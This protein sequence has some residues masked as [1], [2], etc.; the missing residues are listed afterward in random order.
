MKNIII[1]C[2]SVLGVVHGVDTE[3]KKTLLVGVRPREFATRDYY[4]TL[5]PNTG[6]WALTDPYDSSNGAT[7]EKKV[8]FLLGFMNFYQKKVGFNGVRGHDLAYDFGDIY[9]ARPNKAFIQKL[10][11]DFLKN[12]DITDKEKQDLSYVVTKN[13]VLDDEGV[14]SLLDKSFPSTITDP[15]IMYGMPFVDKGDLTEEGQKHKD[16]FDTVIVDHNVMKF[17]VDDIKQE[18]VDRAI[19]ALN[20]LLKVGGDLIV[21]NP[22]NEMLGCRDYIGKEAYDLFI[23][24]GYS[25]EIACEVGKSGYHMYTDDLESSVKRAFSGLKGIMFDD[26]SIEKDTFSG[27]GGPMIRFHNK[28]KDIFSDQHGGAGNAPV[29]VTQML[30]A[31][32]KRMEENEPGKDCTLITQ[33]SILKKKIFQAQQYIEHCQKLESGT[34]SPQYAAAQQY[35]QDASA[36]L[37][38]ARQIPSLAHYVDR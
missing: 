30:G 11:K 10:F 21:L 33:I 14:R 35:M 13:S 27:H 29:L 1:L 25:H 16:K 31:M 18:N 22:G 38:Q 3:D 28:K 4:R 5:A 7:G 9:G 26:V 34:N 2:A 20:S 6:L 12:P 8:D 19:G 15:M 32:R 17:L 37:N 36:V 24:R 23:K